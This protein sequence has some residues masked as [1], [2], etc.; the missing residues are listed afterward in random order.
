M[1]NLNELYKY[2]TNNYPLYENPEMDVNKEHVEMLINCR[3]GAGYRIFANGNQPIVNIPD[4]INC[5][6]CGESAKE[7][8]VSGHSAEIFNVTAYHR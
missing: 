3:C 1:N 7:Q 8:T 5:K 4:G 2:Y 6:N